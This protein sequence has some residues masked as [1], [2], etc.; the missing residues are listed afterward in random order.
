MISDFRF[1]I[2]TRAPRAERRAVLKT[3]GASDWARIGV[4]YTSPA[5][6]CLATLLL[7]GCSNI[8]APRTATV[9][10]HIGRVLESATLKPIAGASVEVLG[11]PETRVLTDRNGYYRTKEA[12][13]RYFGD[14]YARL[15]SLRVASIGHF[16]QNVDWNLNIDSLSLMSAFIDFSKRHMPDVCLNPMSKQ[17]VMWDYEKKQKDWVK[18]AFSNNSALFRRPTEKEFAKFRRKQLESEFGK[19]AV[20]HALDKPGAKDI[21]ELAYPE[22][23]RKRRQLQHGR[24]GSSAT[25]PSDYLFLHKNSAQRSAPAISMKHVDVCFDAAQPNQKS[26]IGN[27]Q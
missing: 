21:Y 26:P 17:S 20:A 23:T 6:A 7:A 19:E 16:P 9:V 1:Q 12:R 25:S 14:A 11:V 3:E 15:T 24:T 5:F 27:R 2:S 4:R 10:P 13:Q 22:F 8:P 18:T